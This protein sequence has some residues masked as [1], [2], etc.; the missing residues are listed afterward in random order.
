MYIIILVKCAKQILRPLTFLL[1]H[2]NPVCVSSF[3]PSDRQWRYL[4]GS[5]YIVCLMYTNNWWP[6]D[7]AADWLC[8]VGLPIRERPL[9]TEAIIEHRWKESLTAQFTISVSDIK[10]AL[11]NI[12]VIE[13]T[14]PAWI[15]PCA[16]KECSHILAALVTAIF[17]SSLRECVRPTV[18]K[19]ATVIPL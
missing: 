14:G 5:L 6:T 4:R 12:K 3:L 9:F 7:S 2:C 10:L 18:W 13:A 11:D 19:T 16:L 15:P 17:N 8:V 1:F